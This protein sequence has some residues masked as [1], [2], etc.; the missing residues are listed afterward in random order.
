MSTTRLDNRLVTEKAVAEIE[1]EI[2][3]DHLH[4]ALTDGLVEAEALLQLLDE[5]R[6]EPLRAAVGG[7]C[8]SAS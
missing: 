1:R 4:K 5:R 6:V 3:A 7:A 8:L 2:V